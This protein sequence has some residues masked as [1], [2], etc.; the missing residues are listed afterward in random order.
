MTTD[1]TSP[2]SCDHAGTYKSFGPAPAGWPAP[3]I[4]RPL[5]CDD[6]GAEVAWNAADFAAGRIPRSIPFRSSH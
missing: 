3:G 6:C 5:T 4:A 1:T 2:R